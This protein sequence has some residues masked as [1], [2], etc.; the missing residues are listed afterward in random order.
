ML[1]WE[2]TKHT[3]NYPKYKNNV[4]SFL[5]G[6]KLTRKKKKDLNPPKIRKGRDR[7]GLAAAQQTP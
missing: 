2:Y 7:S 3:I 5:A 1:H 6:S 4:G